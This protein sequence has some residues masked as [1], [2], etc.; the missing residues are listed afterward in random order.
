MVED[1]KTKKPISKELCKYAC[2]LTLKKGLIA[3]FGAGNYGNVID[4]APPLIITEEQVDSAAQI[5]RE[6]L[7]ETSKKIRG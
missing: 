3:N 4:I 2:D 1:K 7:A 5:M 6:A